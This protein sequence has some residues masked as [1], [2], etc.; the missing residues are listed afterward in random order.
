VQPA[1]AVDVSE[2][3]TVPANPLIAL[4]LTCE[5]PALF[6]VVMMAG[7]ESVKS[8]TVTRTPTV[9]VIAT[10]TPCTVT[11]NGVMPVVH[12]TDNSP[13]VLMDC[14]QP[15]GAVEVIENVT[16][17][18]NP[19][20]A[21]T[22]TCDVPAVLAVVVTAGAESVKSWIVT[23]TLKLAV[24]VPEVPWTI[25]VNVVPVGHVTERPVV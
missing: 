24:V 23:G 12:V 21:L 5:V 14:V 15:A 25:T 10:L 18:A 22:V 4:T 3:V 11:V 8:W 19:L 20:I 6:A 13:A 17:P 1:G 7:A 16:V 9:L 2:K